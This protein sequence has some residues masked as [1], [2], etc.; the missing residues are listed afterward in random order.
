M[1][2]LKKALLPLILILFVAC[3]YFD[4]KIKE[5]PLK[6]WFDQ[7][8]Q[9]W[10]EGLPVGNGSLGAMRY[11]TPSKEVICLNE[12]TIW[13]GEKRYDRDNKNAGP[14]V[15]KNIQQMVFDGKYVEAEK[16][17]TK[18]LLAE[19]LPSGT[20][21]F[22]MLANFFVERTGF[23]S[24]A[25]F[26]RELDLNTAVQTTQ[27]EKDGIT[28]RS[29]VFSSFPDK[30]MIIK[31]SADK[32]KAI[33]L[34]AWI[35]RTENTNIELTENSIHFSEH[36]GKGIGVKFHS[37]IN[38]EAKGGTTKVKDGKMVI[39]GADELVLRIVAASNY[40]GGNP[41][42]ICAD[43]LK[44]ALAGDYK[45][46]Y[47]THV[48]DY[49]SLFKRLNF[50]ISENDGEDLPADKRLQKVKDGTVDNYLTQ[51]QYQFGRYL[52]IRVLV[53]FTCLLI[54]RVYG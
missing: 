19:R 18:N 21:T 31:Y 15:L 17:L 8:T 34:S 44:T 48:A 30:A 29:E 7:P 35:E 51:V 11:G 25:N 54:Y 12:E 24:V 3:S 4:E 53:L 10:N 2:L 38:F 9:K 32:S 37:I 41:E 14:D 28:Y 5:Q 1:S 27:F 16:F 36:V 46:L 47:K 39:T 42:I 26:R 43:N 45:E 50:S 49:R 22:Q 6:I 33:N 40:R 23:D 52:L 20:N 13:T